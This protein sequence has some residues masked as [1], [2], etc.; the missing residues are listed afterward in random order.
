MTKEQYEE[1]KSNPTTIEVFKKITEVRD[2]LKENLSTG[3]TL[4][5]TGDMIV[6]ST[7]R[8]VGNIEG[9]DQLLGMY[10]ED[11]EVV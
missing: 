11:E 3:M 4:S 5:D 10:F 9:L 2:I 1:W 7:A 6:K 8:V